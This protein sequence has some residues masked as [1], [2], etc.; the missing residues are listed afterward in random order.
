MIHEIKMYQDCHFIRPDAAAAVYA[1]GNHTA[2]HAIALLRGARVFCVR[3]CRQSSHR[4]RIVVLSGDHPPAV[5]EVL[6]A[7]AWNHADANAE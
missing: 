2:L 3:L 7:A 4:K 1:C 5:A 6:A